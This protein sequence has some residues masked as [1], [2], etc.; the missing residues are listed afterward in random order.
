M[1][2]YVE[3]D[4]L[5]GDRGYSAIPFPSAEATGLLH[6]DEIRPDRLSFSVARSDLL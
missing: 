6:L 3:G 5:S 2:R 4:G 1:F